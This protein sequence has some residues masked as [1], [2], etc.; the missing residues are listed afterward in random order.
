MKKVV[1]YAVI[2][3]LLVTVVITIFSRSA[4]AKSS[5]S[6]VDE[7]Q[8]TEYTV[9]I[10]TAYTFDPNREI[11]QQDIDDATLEMMEDAKYYSENPL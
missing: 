6:I 1:L 9:V 2:L 8:Q 4:Q 11:T 5:R 7:S 10:D 3:L